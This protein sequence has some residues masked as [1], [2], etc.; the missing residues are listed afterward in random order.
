M[1]H[2]ASK[3]SWEQCI[4]PNMMGS[5]LQDIAGCDSGLD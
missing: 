1:D 3:Y 5:V 2:K 4:V